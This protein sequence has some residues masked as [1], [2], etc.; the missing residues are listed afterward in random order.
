M[1]Y[2]VWYLPGI[3]GGTLIALIAVTH[4]FISHFAVGGGLYL[5]MAE[6]KGLREQNRGIL[7][8]TRSHAKFFML[9][10]M[11]AGGMTGVGI[12]FVISLVQPA[13]T[14]LLIHTFVFGWAAEWVFFLVEIVAVLVYYYTFDRM[15][16]RTHMAVGWVY[17]VS[18]W[19]SLFL[20]TGIIG[21][22]LT[23]G[24]WL[25]NASFWSGF[26]NPS[27]WPSLV[28]RTCIALMFAGVYA[29]VTTAF[30]KDRELKAAMT[31]FSG[32]WVLLAFLPAVPA[33]FWYLSVLPGPARALVA[34]GSPTIQRAL[35][36]G[37]WAVIALLVLSLLLTLARPAAHNKLL[38][39][40]VLGCAFLFMGSFEWTREAARRPY[41]INE[42]MYSNGL[43]EK[44]VTALC[45]EG[46]LPTARWGGMRE[47]HE[48]S[49][50]EAGAALFR[51]Q[52]FA[53]HSVGGPNNDILP[54]TA[55]MPFAALKTYIS[56]LHERRY[57]MPPFA[58]TDAE[59]RALAAYLT[60]G[61]HGK[62]L[63][64]EEPPAVAGADEG[65][66]IFEENCLFCHPLE[67]VE[68]RTSG[69][70]RE[71]VREGIGNLSALNP[72][73]PDFYGTEEE[74]DLLAAYIASLQGSVPV[75]GHDPGEDVFEEHCALCH[76]LEG[77][78]NQLLP[79]IAGW[80]EAKIRA[81]L[82][83]LERLN[84]AMPP[85]SATAAEKDALA[86][87]L[88]ESLKGGAR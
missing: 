31:R 55:T 4:V 67:L 82:D 59:A 61:L 16:P 5:V 53:C 83:G 36:W 47:L 60:A 78:Y 64:P 79:K 62:P 65:R 44:D 88:A 50:V 9:V 85:L 81:A 37:L 38:S 33:G 8:F 14:S 35:E 25:Q 41:V 27:F 48:E 29:F 56:S 71:K 39:F 13:A 15:A 63:P 74:K 42:V 52:C 69:W 22:M 3:G 30:L 68:A 21:F 73:M 45:A 66:T 26:F 70:S 40:V 32:K 84:P 80:D 2:P 72:A 19:L 1:N 18:A 17:F 54:R 49:L 58:G 43:L 20:I 51:V 24:G 46:C 6:R 77:D 11:V 7:D 23:P 34:G 87:F 86:R 76:T 12:W 57:F 75:A 10:T 28:F